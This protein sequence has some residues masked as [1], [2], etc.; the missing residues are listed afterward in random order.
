MARRFALMARRTALADCLGSRYLL[1]TVPFLTLLVLAWFVL[2]QPT[3][4]RASANFYVRK[5][6]NNAYTC[7]DVLHPCLTITAALNKAS[8]GQV[9]DVGTG[10]YTENLII[11]KDIFISGAGTSVTIIDGNNN[12]RVVN[13]S[14]GTNV[15]LA[16][17]TIRNGRMLTHLTEGSGAGIW[18]A[19]TLNLSDVDVVSN[20][21]SLD[22]ACTA[23]CGGGGLYN[24]GTL[25]MVGGTIGYNHGEA[26]GGI[27]NW[28]TLTITDVIIANNTSPETYGTGGG[29]YNIVG[30]ATLDQVTIRNNNASDTG[31]GIR[32]EAVLHVTN[33]TINGNET[34]QYSIYDTGA[35]AVL[36]LGN[37]TVSS[38]HATLSNGGIAVE[39]SARLTLDN[40]TVANNE[41][42]EVNG[43]RMSSAG[44][45]AIYN[46]ILSNPDGNCYSDGSSSTVSYGHNLVSDATCP[47][48]FVATGDITNTN[49]RLAPLGDWGGPTQTHALMY[50]SPAIDAGNYMTATSYAC[51][52]TD[53]RGVTRPVGA[54]CDIGAFEG[55][56]PGVNLPLIRK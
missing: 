38:N 22:A 45:V 26:G 23:Y 41:S 35:S 12:G 6:G 3:P 19:G 37:S 11:T 1:A 48:V 33:S 53:Q 34:R 40:V 4:A 15:F 43:V 2:S 46:T 25:T 21:V 31:G 55:S 8:S 16:A 13:V 36:V 24:G 47:S 14:T 28:G 5:S 42:P 10:T 20:T 30:M 50:G 27:L 49:A 18:N 56:L 17:L 54:G 32:N 29:I 52:A 51:M 44:A 9:I 39:Y 7:A